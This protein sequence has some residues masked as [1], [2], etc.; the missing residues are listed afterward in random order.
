[1]KDTEQ[2]ILKAAEEVFQQKGYS[3]TKMQEIA[4]RAGINAALVHY[5][6]RTKDKLF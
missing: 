1:M 2:I 4:D 5:Y 6:F 3:N